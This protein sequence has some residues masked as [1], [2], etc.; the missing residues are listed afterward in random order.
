VITLQKQEVT[1][2]DL[3]RTIACLGVITLH[4]LFDYNWQEEG[5]SL[6][7]WLT[8]LLHEVAKPSVA[9]F[10][11][12]SGAYLLDPDK[13][14]HFVAFWKKRIAQVV[15]PFLLW[16]GVY[17]L[18]NRVPANAIFG[19]FLSQDIEAHLWFVYMLLGLYAVLPL[20]RMVVKRFGTPGAA[21]LVG[22]WFG[23]LVY[24][25]VSDQFNDQWLVA[26]F[27]GYFLGGYLLRKIKIPTA[28][29]V[30]GILLVVAANTA[31]YHSLEASSDGWFDED[32]SMLC[33][34]GPPVV[35]LSVLAFAAF[36]K[37]DRLELPRVLTR[38]IKLLAHAS[39]GIYL[40]HPLVQTALADGWLGFSLDGETGGPFLGIPLSIATVTLLTVILLYLLEKIPGARAL[41]AYRNETKANR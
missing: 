12:V 24:L 11:M 33:D 13:P 4:V 21:I 10:V 14:F 8:D 27:S 36:L 22:T 18:A 39:Y 37:A 30:P 7:W 38:G 19:K 16:S 41:A 23:I 31:L 3:I 5:S 20:L 28:W 2:T 35:A 26:L 25:A 6:L 17:A 9:L 1:S 40:A 29:L 15:L 32:Y 34:A